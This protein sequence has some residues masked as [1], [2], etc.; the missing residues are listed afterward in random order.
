MAIRVGLIPDRQSNSPMTRLGKSPSTSPSD[1]AAAANW[2][3]KAAEQGDARAQNNLGIM[4]NKGDGVPQ[5][6]VTAYMWLNLAATS[7]F[8]EALRNR[9][10]IAK[11]MTPAQIGE[12]QKLAREWKPR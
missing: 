3:R 5:D 9:D 10:I 2:Y 8:D 4:Y 12:A 7:G 11:R 6:R 1:N